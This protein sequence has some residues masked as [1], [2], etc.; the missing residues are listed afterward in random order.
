MSEF[1]S[2]SA[3]QE[4]C[5]LSRELDFVTEKYAEAEDKCVDADHEFVVEYA[6]AYLTA[7]GTIA[8]REAKATIETAGLRKLSEGAKKNVR[9]YRQR[10]AT[11]G[12]RMD[13]GRTTVSVL[14]LERELDR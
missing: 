8:E 9:V 3:V 6:K 7:T 5:K 2:L 4:L 1:T 11:L 14:K 10:I 13:G 12:R